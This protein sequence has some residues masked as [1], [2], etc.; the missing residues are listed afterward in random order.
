M[1]R[2]IGLIGKLFQQADLTDI[3]KNIPL[4]EVAGNSR[5]LVENHQC[6]MQYT[7]RCICVKVKFGCIKIL[8][9]KLNLAKMTSTQ[10]VING[11]IESISFLNKDSIGRR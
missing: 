5:V 11:D 2:Q 10:V 9:N 6:I 8:G 1:D 3:S 7:T 4:T